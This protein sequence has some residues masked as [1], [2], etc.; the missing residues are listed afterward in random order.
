MSK[1]QLY[2][3]IILHHSITAI[4]P[5]IHKIYYLLLKSISSISS[6]RICLVFSAFQL[7]NNC[8]HLNLKCIAFLFAVNYDM[9]FNIEIAQTFNLGNDK[10]GHCIDFKTHCTN[11]W[12]FCG[13][14]R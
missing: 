2:F 14:K 4:D 7:E 10:P 12:A 3:P 13:P 8:F 1:N 6:Q 9:K 5:E 11:T